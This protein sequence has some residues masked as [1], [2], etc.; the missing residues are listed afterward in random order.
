M[1]N[2]PGGHASSGMFTVPEMFRI[3]NSDYRKDFIDIIFHNLPDTIVII[4]EKG[5]IIDVNISM[6]PSDMKKNLKNIS[7]QNMEELFVIFDIEEEGFRIF[8][9]AKEKKKNI[10]KTVTKNIGERW[11]EFRFN[12]VIDKYSNFKG[13]VIFI[14]DITE[15][16]KLKDEIINKNKELEDLN[17]QLTEYSKLL[18]RK[19]VDLK[20]ANDKLEQLVADLKEGRKEKE[21]MMSIVTHELKKPLTPLVLSLEILTGYSNLSPNLKKYV[22]ISYDSA[23]ELEEYTKELL[24]ISR[25]ESKMVKIEKTEVDVAAFVKE[26]MERFAEEAERN[27]QKLELIYEGDE[28]AKLNSDKML[29]RIIFDNLISNALKYTPDNKNIEIRVNQNNNVWEFFIK[30]TGIGIPEKELQFI[31]DKFHVVKSANVP[32][33]MHRTGIG[34]YTVKKYVEAL[35]GKI[36]VISEIGHGTE[37]IISFINE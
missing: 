4:D 7:K 28:G 22:T 23:K 19:N 17:K 21:E 32:R 10:V 15:E 6:L 29:L 20:T 36:R 9:E 14:H 2:G 11:Y 5:G 33:D 18:E 1:Y 13:I 34:L 26:E 25:I 24:N 8:L 16:K 37:F 12:S 35:N 31:F 3:D 27:H 30:D